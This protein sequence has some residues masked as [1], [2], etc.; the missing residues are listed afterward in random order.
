M[1]LIRKITRLLR[2]MTF[3]LISI[4]VTAF[5]KSQV[6]DGIPNQSYFIRAQKMMRKM[7]RLLGVNLVVDG[8]LPNNSA[9]LVSNHVSWLDIPVVGA[10]I[11]S[12]F[13]SKIEV[14][15][16]PLVGWIAA[17]NGTIFIARGQQGAALRAKEDLFY[18]LSHD[19]NVLLFPEG[20]TSD[21]TDVRKFHPRLFAA[22]VENK[23]NIQPLTIR[24]ENQDGSLNETMP[25][26]EKS[27][28]SHL[29]RILGNQQVTARVSILPAITVQSLSRKEIAHDAREAIHNALHS[30][31]PKTPVE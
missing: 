19:V 15:S 1:I 5:F 2:L 14:K 27:F 8:E 10:I 29:W 20:T 24:Y 6:V 4:L 31:S 17:K 12:L 22:A 30:R 25:F 21:G 13:L 18:A 7:C 28:V 23:S 3:L 16:W 11:P 9:L 26:I